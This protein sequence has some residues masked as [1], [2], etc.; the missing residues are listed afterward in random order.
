MELRELP[1]L[2]GS[3]GVGYSLEDGPRIIGDLAY[4]NVFG[5][6]INFTLR[7]KLNY[8]GA[9][10]LPL[11]DY[12]D[13]SNLQ[14]L[15]GLDFNINAGLS[16]PRIYQVLPARVG[17]RLHVT[18]HRVHRPDLLL[19]TR[20]ALLGVDWAVTRWLQI[21][22]NYLLENRGGRAQP[23]VGDLLQ[24]TE[25]TPSGS[26]SPPATS[27]CRPWNHACLTSATSAGYPQGCSSP[28]PAR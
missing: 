21:T 25:P 17:A 12:V 28:R 14:G 9:S 20:A 18:A 1:R 6:G 13:A 7:G 4:P 15:N 8:V 2:S 23:G 22:G 27:S 3:I 19:R 5:Q 26:A 10:A 11:Q 16:Q 24:R